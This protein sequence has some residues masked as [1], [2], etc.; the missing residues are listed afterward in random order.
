MLN[1]IIL[2][3]DAAWTAE[4]FQHFTC[5]LKVS[6]SPYCQLSTLI[7]DSFLFIKPDSRLLIPHSAT[8]PTLAICTRVADLHPETSTHGSTS[9]ICY[10]WPSPQ[11][12]AS[13]PHNPPDVCMAWLY[14]ILST[15]AGI[16][17]S[18]A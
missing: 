10:V 1:L 17:E 12:Q 15:I 14:H 11:P 5:Y 7:P 3:I 16:T 4:C 8:N 13:K 2:T 9:M 6:N 18:G